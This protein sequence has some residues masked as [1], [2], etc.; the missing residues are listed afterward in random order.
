MESDAF[1]KLPFSPSVAAS[2]QF[3]ITAMA[4]LTNISLL[5]YSAVEIV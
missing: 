4:H 5:F 1:A 2:L 3:L